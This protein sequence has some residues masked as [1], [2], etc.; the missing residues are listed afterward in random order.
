MIAEVVIFNTWIELLTFACVATGGCWA[1]MQWR[2]QVKRESA[3]FLKEL[4]DAFWAIDNESF[5][6]DID[7]GEQWYD[8]EFHASDKE[9][10]VDRTL[11]FFSYMC[12][13]RANGLFGKS[14]FE[15][16]DYDLR[17]VLGNSQV[18]DYLYNVHH[19]SSKL[20][21][22]SPFKCLVEFGIECELISRADFFDPTLH[23]RDR[24]FHRYLNF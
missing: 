23:M 11:T 4:L 22:T 2:R 12:F 17:R 6:Y 18:I 20:G 14:G 5:I 9:K 10:V 19:F 21:F 15:Y 16:F 1:I 24:Q 3:E 13:L 8:S 7:Y